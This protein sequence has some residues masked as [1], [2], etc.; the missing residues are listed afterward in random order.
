MEINKTGFGKQDLIQR[1]V[2]RSLSQYVY[3]LLFTAKVLAEKVIEI[4]SAGV[5]K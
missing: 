5:P 4:N 1:F 2:I 3:I